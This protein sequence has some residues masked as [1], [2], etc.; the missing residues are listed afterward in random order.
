MNARHVLIRAL[1]P[2]DPGLREVVTVDPGLREV[3]RA[4]VPVDPGRPP[5]CVGPA[6]LAVAPLMVGGFPRHNQ[7]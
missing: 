5:A 3:I 4:L 1:V 6:A 2:V 7:R